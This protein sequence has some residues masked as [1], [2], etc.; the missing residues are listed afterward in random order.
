MSKR[1]RLLTESSMK[2]V[3]LFSAMGLAGAVGTTAVQ[4]QEVGRVISSTPVIQQVAVNRQVCNTQPVAVQQPSS[5]G[6]ALLGAIVGGVIGNQSGHGFGR[7]AATGIGAV[8]GAAVGNNV[9]NPGYQPG[10]A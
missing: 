5:G 3:L 2:N 9:E 1:K 4:A 7:A 10:Y 6:G 8:A